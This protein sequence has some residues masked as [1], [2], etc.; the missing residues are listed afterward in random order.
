MLLIKVFSLR[1]VVDGVVPI[2]FMPT[3]KLFIEPTERVADDPDTEPPTAKTVAL[4]LAKIFSLSLTSPPP[5][6]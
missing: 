4:P 6:I 3:V 1:L 2:T 5:Q